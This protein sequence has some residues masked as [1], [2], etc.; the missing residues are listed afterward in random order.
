MISEILQKTHNNPTGGHIGQTKLYKKLRREFYWTDFKETIRNF[1][2]NCISC[3]INK[4]Q[5]RTHEKFIKT[6]TPIS[7]FEII[8][9]DTVGPFQKTN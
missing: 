9:I 2:K 6:T 5:R 8:T 1:V 4:H 7:P 3:K